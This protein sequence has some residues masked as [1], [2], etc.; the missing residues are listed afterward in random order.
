M[1]E[2]LQSILKAVEEG[3]MTSR[4]A[5]DELKGYENLGYARVDS[6][7]SKR[8]GFPEVVYGGGKT[9]EQLVEITATIMKDGRS[10]LATRISEE[11]AARVQAF[12]NEITYD[13][14]SRLLYYRQGDVVSTGR[15][16]GV[17]CAGTSDLRVAEEA[18]VTA[19]VMG[20]EV[21]RIY[22]V[23]VA[24]LHRL[25]DAL[26][27]IDACD[28]LIVVAGMEGAL[29]SVVGGLA[30]QPL[31]A[32]PTSVGYGANMEG[33]ATLLGMLNSCSSGIT[34]VNIDNGFGA[35]YS[36]TL[37]NRIGWRENGR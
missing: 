7:R 20:N 10:V 13:P 9:A 19:D 5:H 24:G 16:V 11:K 30:P 26:P 27:E 18:A 2:S 32:V 29:P 22:D 35:A 31:I 12:H 15:R 37:M 23:G 6:A 21:H 34:V 17:L 33:L 28:V 36:A 8:K 1:R 25:L 3:K 14:V 4:E